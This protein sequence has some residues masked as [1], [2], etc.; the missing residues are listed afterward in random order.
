M[1]EAETRAMQLEQRHFAALDKAERLMV[2][3][4]FCPYLELKA[5]LPDPSPES[6]VRF[7]SLFT[8]YYGLNVGGLTNEFKDKF[9]ETLFAGK[10]LLNGQ[11][12]FSGILCTLSG[13]R[14]KQGD[15][16]MPFSFVSKLVAIHRE[17]SPIYDRHVLAFFGKKAPAASAKVA[18]RIEWYQG[19]LDHVSQS[20]K[21]WAEDHRVAQ[22]MD[23]FKSRDALL[24]SCH[25]VRLMDFLV[26]KVGNQKLL[27]E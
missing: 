25:V 2:H 3:S 20:Y 27:S 21:L 26:W 12:D 24:A 13:L 11:P 1:I 5:M 10:V 23:R 15:Y 6:R 9:F 18:T 7:R 14:R 17:A 8:T 16:A 4:D 22:I 19:F